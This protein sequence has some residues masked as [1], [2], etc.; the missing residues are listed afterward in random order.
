[1]S[2]AQQAVVITGRP[3]LAPSAP[4]D[5]IP[6]DRHDAYRQGLCVD[7]KSAWASAGRPRCQSCHDVYVQLGRPS[8][9]TP[10]MQGQPR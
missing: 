8:P 2:G 1:M 3:R 4:R 9:Y 5:G 10:T 7:C 6:T